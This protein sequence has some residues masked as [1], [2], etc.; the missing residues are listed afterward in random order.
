[1][2]ERQIEMHRTMKKLICRTQK[3]TLGLGLCVLAASGVIARAEAGGGKSGLRQWLEQDY[4]LGDWGGLRT[5]LREEHGVDFEFMYAAT[6]P[7]AVGGGLQSGSVYEGGLL[8]MLNVDTAK[9]GAWENGS[10]RASS[11]SMHSGD[12]FALNYVGDLNKTS[13]LDFP[14]TF[15]LWEL[16]YEHKFFD[17][18]LSVKAGQLD[19]GMDFIVPEYYNSVG[20]LS[21]LNQTF[22]FPTMAFNVY[23]QPYFP[24]GNHALAA[25]PYAAPGVRVRYDICP[26]VYVQAGVYDGNPDRGFSGTDFDLRK[27]EGA[28]SYFEVGFKH[29]QGK[30]ATGL[31]GN[32][33]IGA[34]YHTDDFY[35]MYE[36]TFVAF[37]NYVA[38]NGLP[39][40]PVS[41]GNATP[42]QGNSGFYILVDHVLWREPGQTEPTQQGL[43]GF[44][45]VAGA[46]RNRNLAQVGIDGGLVYKGLIPTRDWDTFGVALSYLEISDELRRAQADINAAFGA[47]GPVLPEADYEAV[48]E[49]NY[50]AQVAAWCAVDLSLQRVFHPGG[51]VVAEIPDAWAFIVQTTFRF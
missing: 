41:T 34:W 28:L 46:P 43:A 39:L 51:R 45:R 24:V 42:R 32:F 36:G 33:K 10:F 26:S 7:M 5:R 38:A 31:P 25:T 30:D 8:M 6:V 11:L 13:L 4:M 9:L 15:R 21:F 2:L 40:P 20:Q 17:G 22:F 50:K 3:W 23:D 16:F 19:I 47:F 35:D 27:E 29:N 18:K 14:D 44:F 48:L 12:E 37:D 49:V 1:M